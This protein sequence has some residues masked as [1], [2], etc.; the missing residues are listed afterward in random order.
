VDGKF[1]ILL[2]LTNIALDKP[3][4]V[5][6]DTIYP[7]VSKELLEALVLDLSHR[8]NWYQKQIRNKMCQL[9][10]MGNRKEILKLIMLFN[11]EG[12]N[13][14]DMEVLS[15]ISLIK[16]NADSATQNYVI[17]STE[18]DSIIPENWRDLALDIGQGLKQIRKSFFELSV[19]SILKK[20]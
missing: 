5:I 2:K 19:S 8:G 13:S 6:K 16:D 11:F 9:Y 12:E 18:L 17:N 3:D 10:S 14:S 4:G 7:E 1:E 20:S 15:A